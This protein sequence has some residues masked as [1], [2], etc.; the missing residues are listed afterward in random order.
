MNFT[1]QLDLD[2]RINNLQKEVNGFTN[3]P[4]IITTSKFSFLSTFKFSYYYLYV[5]I[6]FIILI[7]FAI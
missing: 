6:P 5:G 2:E 7:I 3:T 1:K 4:N